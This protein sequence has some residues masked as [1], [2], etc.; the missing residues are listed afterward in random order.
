MTAGS[1]RAASRTCTVTRRWLSAVYGAMNF[2]RVAVG[3]MVDLITAVVSERCLVPV[4]V[5]HVPGTAPVPVGLGAPAFAGVDRHIAVGLDR[6]G[7]E[8][9]DVTSSVTHSPVRQG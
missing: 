4:V 5:P 2:T 1:G 3:A 8:L 9:E 6:E 7:G